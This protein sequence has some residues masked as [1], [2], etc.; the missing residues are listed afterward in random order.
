MSK[1]LKRL[2]SPRVLR[3]NRKNNKWTIKPSPG[4]HKISKSVSLGLIVR[5]Y[6]KLCDS[7]KEAKRIIFKKE[8]L[9]DNIIRTD[10]KF[11]CGLMD[12]I[13]IPKMKKYYRILFDKAGKLT[14]MPINSSET[15]WKLYRIEGKTIIKGKKTQLNLHDGKNIIVDKDEYRR[16]DVL[17]IRFKDTKILESY[18]LTKG[19]TS[20]IIGGSHIGEIANIADLTIISS[21]KSNI[22]NMKGKNEFLTIQEYVFPIGKSKAVISIPEV[23]IL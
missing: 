17:K 11:P 20:M 21:S 22:A 13:S 16:G 1:H 18:A 12:V 19:N 14:L 6:L 10:Y 15:E 7:L 4:P 5:D 3:L 8:I 2:N 9:V 23:K